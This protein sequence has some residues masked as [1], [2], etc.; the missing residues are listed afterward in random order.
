MLR[1]CCRFL[2]FY[3]LISA[4]NTLLAT[5]YTVT[6]L[7]YVG[8]LP[9]EMNVDA[10]TSVYVHDADTERVYC[11]ITNGNEAGWLPKYI[12]D[13][14][15]QDGKES[16][17]DQPISDSN[18][19]GPMQ[20]S[21]GSKHNDTECSENMPVVEPVEPVVEPV[22][23]DRIDESSLQFHFA[24][25]ESSHDQH[26]SQERP[27]KESQSTENESQSTQQESQSQTESQQPNVLISNRKRQLNS[28]MN[29]NEV[30]L[31]TGN[32]PVVLR[33][34]QGKRECQHGNKSIMT[35]KWQNKHYKS[36]FNSVS[37]GGK[38]IFRCYDCL[39]KSHLNIPKADVSFYRDLKDRKRFIISK[40]FK[41][42]IENHK[43]IQQDNHQCNGREHDE[44]EVVY[45][46]ILSYAK[47]YIANLTEPE[48]TLT[49]D[50]LR[51][52]LAQLYRSMGNK[53]A[54]RLFES[55]PDHQSH[56]RGTTESIDKML[57]AKREDENTLS[58][59]FSVYDDSLYLIDTDYY[60]QTGRKLFYHEDSLKYL[61]DSDG[62]VQID[63]LVR[64]RCKF[65]ISNVS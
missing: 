45:K 30:E 55:N 23:E 5:G 28:S 15:Y 12:I 48:R 51:H 6:K 36:Y 54:E 8:S 34:A 19:T 32:L 17:H 44:L 11:S 59:D 1:R 63:G 41:W 4:N 49:D 60:N 43:I 2:N 3:L 65:S 57:K 61:N 62:E 52:S 27:H 33:F 24:D 9:D 10:G 40:E 64:N 21:F 42:N 20:F 39:A 16:E 26:E 22:V 29:Q 46:Q 13:E 37:K 31:Q 25:A 14:N 56:I 50:V 7:T 35:F 38:V 18:D 58:E 47:I 53:V